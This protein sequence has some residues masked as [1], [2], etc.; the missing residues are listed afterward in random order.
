MNSPKI[1]ISVLLCIHFSSINAQPTKDAITNE[2]RLIK[3][4][5]KTVFIE[6]ARSSSPSIQGGG[7]ALEIAIGLIG[8]GRSDTASKALI[9]LLG[10]SL[11]GAGSEERTCQFLN[12]GKPLL[13]NLEHMKV[14]EVVKHCQTMF[15]ELRMRELS[16]VNDVNI[17]DVCSSADS[18]RKAREDFISAIKSKTLCED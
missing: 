16:Q 5:E 10:V 8:I 13:R 7:G 6:L 3:A 15:S 1:F 18:I 17:N 14:E 11:D 4:A 2:D 12:R 9:N